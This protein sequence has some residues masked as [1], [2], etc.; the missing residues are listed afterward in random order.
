MQAKIAGGA[1]MFHFSSQKEQMRI[2]PR[3]IEAVKNELKLSQNSI[4][5]RE[6]WR[7]IMGERLNYDP[8]TFILEIRTVHQD[9]IRI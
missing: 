8:E 3:N 5:C 4:S 2:G 9:T 1:Q 7:T 6:H